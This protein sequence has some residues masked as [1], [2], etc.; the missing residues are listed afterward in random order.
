MWSRRPGQNLGRRL[1]AVITERQ[2]PKEH[3][4]IEMFWVS[5]DKWRPTIKSEEFSQTLIVN[6]GKVYEQ[7]SDEYFPLGL[8]VL[9]TAMVDPK[10]ILDSLRPGDRV[11]TKANGASDESG[12]VC[13][14]ANSKICMRNKYG[15]SESLG[16]P[17][18]SVDF[19]D[20]KK[21]K[22]QRVARLLTYRIDPGDSLQ[23]R[24]TA[25][26]EFDSRDEGQFSVTDPTP[27]EKQIRSMVVPEADLRS[28]ALEPVEF[29]WPQVLEDNNTRGDTSVSLDRSGNVREIFPLSVAV[30]RADHS[31]RRQIMKWKFKPVLRDGVPVQAEGVLNPHFDTRAYGPPAPLTDAE[32][33][34]LASNVVD[35]EFP[36]GAAP[37]GSACTLAIAVDIEGKIIE[38]MILDGPQQI[39]QA[40]S[41]AVGKWQFRPIL[42]EGKPHPYRA[43]ITCRVL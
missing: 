38:S 1:Q 13:F 3:V 34:K 42:E 15:L 35:P 32:V 9:A 18:R 16:A 30:E 29:I 39:Y 41:Q 36:P 43:R 37:P 10:P 40:C 33:R 23:A 5:P 20:Y 4:D 22:G 24:I 17:G 19:T 2:D 26:G 25:L 6:R 8:Q 27:P 14:S 11:L 31:A 21:F 12:R 28:N 7:D